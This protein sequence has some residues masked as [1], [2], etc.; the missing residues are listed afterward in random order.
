MIRCPP[1]PVVLLFSAAMSA[2]VS[3]SGQESNAT[4]SSGQ[5]G[6]SATDTALVD[7]GL[8]DTGQGDTSQSDTSQPHYGLIV[9]EVPPDFTLTDTNLTSPTYDQAI[10]VSEKTGHVTGWHFY[11]SS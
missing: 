9:G 5:P 3:P 2:C 4:G 8:A 1:H 11:K 10:T 7:S 6:D